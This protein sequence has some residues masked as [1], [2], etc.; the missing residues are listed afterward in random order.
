MVAAPPSGESAIALASP[1]A[2]PGTHPGKFEV[3]FAAVPTHD[4]AQAVWQHLREKMPTLLGGRQPTL[5]KVDHDGHVFWRVRTGGF[6]DE[7]Q[8]I[9]FC[10]QVQAAGAACV[11]G[12]P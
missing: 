4:A 10:H 7:P 5:I 6:P 8:A 2:H 1:A 3:Q 11:L 12:G 9:V